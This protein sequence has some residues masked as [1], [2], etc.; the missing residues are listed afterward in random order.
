MWPRPPHPVPNV[1]DDREAPLLRA[2]M[3]EVV[4]MIW[5]VREAIYFSREGWTGIRGA[6]PSGK[7]VCEEMQEG[8]AAQLFLIHPPAQ[9][10]EGGAQRRV[11]ALPR[12]PRYLGSSNASR[13]ACRSSMRSSA[14][15]LSWGR[16]SRR[17]AA[18]G[19]SWWSL[20]SCK[21]S[22]SLNAFRES[23][24]VNARL[25]ATGPLIVNASSKETGNPTKKSS[26]S[27]VPKSLI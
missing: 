17:K 6:R 27:I 16:I 1:P 5:V 21:L 26:G 20:R 12:S 25:R 8:A 24:I 14:S 9:R 18:D 22:P 23:Y 10:G 3:A 11:G 15:I 13:F 19:P 4:M 7:S 2:G